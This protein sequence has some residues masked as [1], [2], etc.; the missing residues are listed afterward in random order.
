MERNKCVVTNGTDNHI[1]LLNL[2]KSYG[3]NG[4]QGEEFLD[5]ANIVVNKNSCSSDTSVLRPSAIRIGSPALTTRGL[6]ERGFL[7]VCEFMNQVFEIASEIVKSYNDK[8]MSVPPAR[9]I[10]K[11]EEFKDAK[12]K[13]EHIKKQV[14]DFISPYPI[15]IG[16]VRY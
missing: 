4:Q 1:V 10:L 14:Y 12:V 16:L 13:L 6:D 11:L 3:I 15:P 9:E 2:F 5:I 7:Q 8:N